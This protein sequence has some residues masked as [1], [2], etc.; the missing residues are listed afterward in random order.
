M[1]VLEKAVL[2]TLAYADIFD[3]P[4]AVVEIHRFLIAPKR[5][6]KKQI[7]VA[8]ESLQQDKR[9]SNVG[10]MYCLAERDSITLRRNKLL[11]SNKKKQ[12]RAQRVSNV[13]AMIPSVL[14][15]FLTG[16]VAMANAHEDD[17]IDILLITSSHTLWSTRIVTSFILIM[18]GV[19]RRAV[20]VH[21]HDLICPNMYLDTEALAVPEQARS[22]YT[23]HEVVQA[24]P[25]KDKDQL[26]DR[27]LQANDWMR[28][29]LPN[30]SVNKLQIPAVTY[31]LDLRFLWSVL[32]K[33][34]NI[35]SYWIQ[36]LYMRSKRTSEKTGIH[37]A[38]FHPR[39]SGEYVSRAYAARCADIG[40]S[41]ID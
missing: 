16:A 29:Y 3:Y 11:L 24:L 28:A 14:A 35:P 32:M 19:R 41:D 36:L 1:R 38:Y 22:L 31:G 4:L 20:S 8:L 9:V 33:L 26:H 12:A 18:M 25:L 10:D 5:Y 39:K 34:V 6:N 17:D 13:L 7:T 23:A 40:I 15:V 27:F 2:R 37:F 21:V 30:V